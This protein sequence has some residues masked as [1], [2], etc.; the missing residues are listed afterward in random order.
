MKQNTSISTTVALCVLSFFAAVGR[1]DNSAPTP[2][3]D[4]RHISV[5]GQVR[6]TQSAVVELRGFIGDSCQ[7][8]LAPVVDIDLKAQRITI[9]PMTKR[10]GTIC[11]EIYKSYHQK[12]NLGRLPEGRYLVETYDRSVS[13]LLTVVAGGHRLRRACPRS[14]S[15]RPSGRPAPGAGPLR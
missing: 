13:E 4:T 14:R 12:I 15:S 11:Q 6:T 9:T 3:R 8:L 2:I 1:G 10:E 7:K 5:P